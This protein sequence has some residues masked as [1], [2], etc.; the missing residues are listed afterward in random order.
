[1]KSMEEIYNEM[2]AS[3]QRETGLEASATSDLAVRLYAVAAQIHTLYIQGDW[4]GRQCFPQTAG[5]E[6]LDLHA[7]LRGLTRRGA[8]AARGVIRFVV[9]TPGSTDL[10]IPAGTVC[11]TAGLVRFETDGDVTLPSGATSA[12]A[13]ATAAEP[14]AAGNVPGGSI[15][16]MAV[17]PMGVSRCLNPTSF[18]GGR[19]REDDEELRVRVLETYRRMPNGAN[20]AFY[21]QGAMSFD[22][23]AAATVIP[24]SRGVGTVDVVVATSAGLPDGTLLQTLADYFEERREIAVDVQV[25]A[26]IVKTVNVSMQIAPSEGRTASAVLAAVR[27]ALERYFDGT[28][29]GKNI[30]KARLCELALSVEG[31]ENCT[32]SAP[33]VDV[34]ITAGELP[35]LGTLTVSAMGG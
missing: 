18:T 17:A 14:G 19:D 11:M 5:G 13:R 23:V 24:R 2:L 32:V 28:R 15:L 22:A 1:M 20:A 7:Q 30:Y 3:F 31:V 33:T 27:A 34:A 21:Q 35:R 12:E 16:T 26:P 6:Y 4:V 9:D 29:L 10:I 8:A 25:K